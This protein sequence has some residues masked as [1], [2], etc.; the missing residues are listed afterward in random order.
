MAHA[1]ATTLSVESDRE[2]ASEPDQRRL[3]EMLINL[4]RVDRSCRPQTAL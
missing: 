4:A 2:P 3:I 1:L